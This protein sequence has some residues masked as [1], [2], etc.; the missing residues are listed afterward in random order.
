VPTAKVI[1]L[2][3]FND[4]DAEDIQAIEELMNYKVPI[5]ELPEELTISDRIM[6]CDLPKVEMKNYLV[7]NPSLSDGGRAFHERAEHNQKVNNKI[8][9]ADAMMKKYGKPK[10]RGQKRK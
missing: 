3:F 8:T 2:S 4:R 6:Q 10:T 5:V 9:R 1:A 7:K